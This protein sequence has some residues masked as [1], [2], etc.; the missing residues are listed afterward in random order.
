LKVDAN[1]VGQE[2]ELLRNKYEP[3]FFILQVAN[4][5]FSA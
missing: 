3:I 2:V 4:R 5:F 1:P